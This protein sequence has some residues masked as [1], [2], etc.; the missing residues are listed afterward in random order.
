[1]SLSR[2]ARLNTYDV[3]DTVTQAVWIKVIS[4]PFGWIMTLWEGK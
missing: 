2:R 4:S 1:M 3:L